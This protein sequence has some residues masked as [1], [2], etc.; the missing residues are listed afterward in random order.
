MAAD[1]T[2]ECNDGG[3]KDA[4]VVRE[5]AGDGVQRQFVISKQG[6]PGRLCHQ[7]YQG[8]TLFADLIA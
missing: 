5:T 6:L 7:L 8:K 3:A 4:A 1:S 2:V